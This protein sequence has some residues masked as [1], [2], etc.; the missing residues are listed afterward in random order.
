M[1]EEIIKAMNPKADRHI[2]SNASFGEGAKPINRIG[3][4]ERFKDTESRSPANFHIVSQGATIDTS[5]ATILLEQFETGYFYIITSIVAYQFNAGTPL[6]QLSIRRRG[7]ND[8]IVLERSNVGNAGDSVN[9]VGEFVCD[10]SYQI[11]ADF[12]GANGT[13]SNKLHLHIHGYKIKKL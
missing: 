3:M 8:K 12:F 11:V 7:D 6:I 10:D 2:P 5:Q 13:A 4:A 9:A 1:N